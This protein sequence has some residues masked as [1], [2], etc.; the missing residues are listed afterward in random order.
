MLAALAYI[1]IG[2]LTN[3]MNRGFDTISTAQYYGV[4]GA[5][6]VDIAR[7]IE[8]ATSKLSKEQTKQLVD[9]A[10]NKPF[11]QPNDEF[12]GIAK[13]KNVIQ[14]QVESL[15]G[16]VINQTVNNKEVT[17]NLDKL[18]ASS[19]FFPNNRFVIGGGH[20]ADTDFV[21][22][23][24]YFP[25]ID[26][27]VFIRYAQDDFT[28]LPK[29]LTSN[30]YS[31]YAY[32]G[33]NRNFWNRD[34]ALRSIGYQKFYAAD[35]YPNG[36]VINMGLNDGD[37]L[38]KTAEF[39]QNQPKPSLSY[40]I[41]LSSHT[42]FDI[43]DQTKALGI[44]PDDYP[45]MV[46]GYLENINYT[47][48]MLG[49]FFDKLK[50]E[51]LYDDS[52]IIVYGDHTPDLPAFTAGTIKYDPTSVQ[53]KEV[54]LIVKLPNKA[55]GQ[56]YPKQGTSLDIVPTVLDLLDIKTP[57]LMFGHS[58]FTEQSSQYQICPD[59]L[60]V[61]ADSENCDSTISIEK[62]MSEKVIQY[63]LFNILPH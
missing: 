38:S 4:L 18:A 59:Q 19:Q 62:D 40:T 60:V 21:S 17:P 57:E 16:F 56:T 26:S 20:T 14:I 9:W 3:A 51:G 1:G 34:S 49:S 53:Y 30:G 2:T 24:S 31:A 23:T 25:L 61:L 11:I 36:A 35:S 12:T 33:Y 15:G 63:N 47:D 7:F 42:P 45:D 41:T 48:R 22:N 29:I 10:K 37:F 58:L 27:A 46:G 13:G 55:N 43:T 5:H 54:P 6:T 28:S 8:Q 44:N 52:L 32:H 50:A 39:I